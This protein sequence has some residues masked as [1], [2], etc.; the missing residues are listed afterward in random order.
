MQPSPSNVNRILAADTFLSLDGGVTWKELIDRRYYPNYEGIPHKA[1]WVNSSMI[2]I[3]IQTKFGIILHRCSINIKGENHR[4]EL[5]L[6]DIKN[7]VRN[8]DVII[9]SI[10]HANDATKNSRSLYTSTDLGQIWNRAQVPIF[11]SHHKPY[12]YL[13]S[14]KLSFLTMIDEEESCYDLYVSDSQHVSYSLSLKCIYE[15]RTPA[16]RFGLEKLGNLDNVYVVNQIQGLKQQPRM[17]VTLNNGL[18]D[19]NGGGG[20]I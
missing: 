16:G 17:H 6:T 1:M 20:Y 7:F 3:S 12:V 9:A 19:F 18:F 4:C 15:Q 11:Q 10:Y 5:L 13:L 14:D 8:G 2:L